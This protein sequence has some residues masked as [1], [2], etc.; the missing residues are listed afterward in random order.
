MNKNYRD[1]KIEDAYKKMF[2]FFKKDKIYSRAQVEKLVNSVYHNETSIIPSDYCYN[3]IN[4]DIAE[5]FRRRLH[6]FEYV[7]KN[8]YKFI[9]EH[10]SYTGAIEYIDRIVGKWENGTLIYLNTDEIK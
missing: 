7:A 8:S 9:G 5:D 2:S 1:S 4:K 10:A 6:V 3:R